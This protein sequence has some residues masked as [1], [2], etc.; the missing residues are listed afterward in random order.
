MATQ[1]PGHKIKMARGL[2]MNALA[3]ASPEDKAQALQSIA[4]IQESMGVTPEPVALHEE[5]EP[6]EPV[7]YWSPPGDA[8]KQEASEDVAEGAEMPAEPEGLKGQKLHDFSVERDRLLKKKAQLEKLVERGVNPLS[9]QIDADSIPRAIEI[10]YEAER[11]PRI[12]KR[13]GCFNRSEMITLDGYRPDHP[14]RFNDWEFETSNPIEIAFIERRIKD[15]K[16][17]NEKPSLDNQHL[18]SS[19][20]VYDLGSKR[21]QVNWEYTAMFAGF[22]DEENDDMNARLKQ[23][24]PAHKRRSRLAG[25]I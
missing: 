3:D 18:R 4:E 15:R 20:P 5:T 1:S 25:R 12:T 6:E 22:D 24:L 13:Y 10:L 11:I 17:A 9:N 14:I 8:P 2:M 7:A 21:A 19:Q 23:K 16:D